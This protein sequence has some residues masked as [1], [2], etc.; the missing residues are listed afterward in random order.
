MDIDKFDDEFD[1]WFDKED[2][3]LRFYSSQYTEKDIAYA[4]AYW[5]YSYIE[6]NLKFSNEKS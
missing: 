2:T 4:A 3:Q 6:K 1:K 5:A